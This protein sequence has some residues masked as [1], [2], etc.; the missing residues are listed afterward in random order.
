MKKGLFLLFLV[1]AVACEKIVE[2]E[3]SPLITRFDFPVTTVLPGDQLVVRVGGTDN[4]ELNQVRLRVRSAF[5]KAYS[6]WSH[7]DIRDIS[8]NA[9]DSEMSYFV[10]DSALAGFYEINLQFS[11]L[12]GNGSIDSTLYFTIERPGEAPSILNF[13]TDPG[14][15]TEGVIFLSVGDTLRFFGQVNDDEALSQVAFSLR[16]RGNSVISSS[17]TVFDSLVT[18]WSITDESKP[19]P[20]VETT[21]FPYSLLVQV[22]DTLGNLTRLSIPV[23]FQ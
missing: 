19:I 17:S 7:L 4:Q 12:R 9:Y 2:D 21:Q 8:G 3:V 11:D 22:T 20:I 18:Q 10:P 13:S 14:A 15:N 23:S 5:N 6:A 1:G 16:S